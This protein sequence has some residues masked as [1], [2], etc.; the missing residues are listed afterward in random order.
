[1]NQTFSI[2]CNGNWFFTIR[3]S[4]FYKKSFCYSSSF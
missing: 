4:T 3:R 2:N 1:M